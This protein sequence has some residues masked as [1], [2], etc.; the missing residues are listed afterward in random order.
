MEESDMQKN[1][2][3][4]QGFLIIFRIVVVLLFLAQVSAVLGILGIGNKVVHLLVQAVFFAFGAFFVVKA[5][6]I[7]TEKI[8]LPIKEPRL[9][10][11]AALSV[12]A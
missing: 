5:Y 12:R 4:R 7:T 6:Y 10:A 9:S 2:G 3:I 11:A 8:L 1:I